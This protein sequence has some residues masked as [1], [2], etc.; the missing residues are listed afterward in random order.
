MSESCSIQLVLQKK[1]VSGVKS[2]Q[3]HRFYQLMKSAAHQLFMCS[4]QLK[5]QLLFAG[6]ETGEQEVTLKAAHTHFTGCATFPP[7]HL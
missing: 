3:M 6:R 1:S 2:F 4:L 5:V 7:L